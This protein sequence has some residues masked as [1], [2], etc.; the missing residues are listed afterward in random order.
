M[1][2]RLAFAIA[3]GVASVPAVAQ[4]M[5]LDDA[6][7]FDAGGG[8]WLLTTDVEESVFQSPP[9]RAHLQ[10]IGLVKTCA[11]ARESV[12]LAVADGTDAFRPVLVA[13]MRSS[14]PAERWS[15][16][17]WRSFQGTLTPYRDRV[18]D[19]L[20]R[21]GAPIYARARD[22]ALT[23]F[24]REAAATAPTASPWADIFFDWDLSRNI[25]VRHACSQYGLAN[26]ANGKRAFDMFY[27]RKE[28]R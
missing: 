24:E 6:Q 3:L 23:H 21:D 27:Q 12:R 20:H 8:M 13:T 28:T 11:I 9:M 18:I 7:V 16:P 19:A 15:M 17:G 5:T 2:L 1:I 22:L 14:I 10:R 25:A 26:P 4:T